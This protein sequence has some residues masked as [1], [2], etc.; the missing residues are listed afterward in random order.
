MDAVMA[1]A[2]EQQAHREGDVVEEVA[3]VVV[4]IL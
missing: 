2:V 1:E 4:R 3:V